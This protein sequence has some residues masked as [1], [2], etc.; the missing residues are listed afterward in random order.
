LNQWIHG[1]SFLFPRC[2]SGIAGR[3]EAKNVAGERSSA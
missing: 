1:S 3:E 2:F